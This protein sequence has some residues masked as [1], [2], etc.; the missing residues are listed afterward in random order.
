MNNSERTL[1]QG[2]LEVIERIVYKS[3]DDVAVSISRSFERMEERLDASESRIYGR[4]AE[5][6]DRIEGSRQQMT[7]ELGDVRKEIRLMDE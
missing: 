2:D 4:L 6:D 5:L 7:D 1:T 3:A